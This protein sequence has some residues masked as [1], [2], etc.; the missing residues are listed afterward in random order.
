MVDPRPREETED[1]VLYL[2]DTGTPMLL[3]GA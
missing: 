3:R 1:F 2:A